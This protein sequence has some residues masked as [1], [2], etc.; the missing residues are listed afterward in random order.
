MLYTIFGTA[1]FFV[2]V[3]LTLLLGM[4]YRGWF[5]PN[6]LPR[7]QWTEGYRNSSQSSRLPELTVRQVSIF[8]SVYVFFQVWNQINCRSLVPSMSGLTNLFANPTFL[9]IAGTIAVVQ[10]LITSVP[11]LGMPWSRWSRSA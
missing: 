5:D 9:S 8:F 3:M 11:F 4:E 2:V 7:D 1:T 10:V 6:W